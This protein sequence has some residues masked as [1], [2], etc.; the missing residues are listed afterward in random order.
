MPKEDQIGQYEQKFS[1]FPARRR[2]RCATYT[3]SA[4]LIHPLIE[5][6]PTYTKAEDPNGNIQKSYRSQAHNA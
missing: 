4:V 5:R 3:K 2:F 1:C 6:S